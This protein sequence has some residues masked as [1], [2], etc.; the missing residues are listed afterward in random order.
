MYSAYR[1][2]NKVL[3]TVT[4]NGS[5]FVKAFKEHSVD[6]NAILADPQPNENSDVYLPQHQRCAPHTLT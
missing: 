1:I 4:D 6:V 3:M 2:Q 5:N